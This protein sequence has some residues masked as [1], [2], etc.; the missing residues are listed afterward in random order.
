M[1]NFIR[2]SLSVLAISLAPTTAE[3]QNVASDMD[4]RG[5]SAI[6]VTGSPMSIESI[7][8][9]VDQ[10]LLI[11]QLQR[12]FENEGLPSGDSDDAL[13]VITVM[14]TRESEGPCSSAI[15]LGAYKKASFFDNAAEWLRTGYFVVWQSGLL[16]ASQADAHAALAA[17]S[18]SRLGEAML[19]EW[20]RTN[21]DMA[22]PGL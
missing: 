11:R 18:L 19:A 5:V 2:L 7:D 1:F 12:Q 6:R 17:D 9:K 21:I 16:F 10:R 4:F 15:M 3:A 14:S 20:H 13:A 22:T 8:C